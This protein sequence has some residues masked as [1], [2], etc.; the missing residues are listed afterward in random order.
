VKEKSKEVWGGDEQS[1]A[2]RTK[3][4]YRTFT[5]GI[6]M[7]Q[8]SQAN[9]KMWQAMSSKC[10]KAVLPKTLR[11]YECKCLGLLTNIVNNFK[12]K[13]LN[14]LTQMMSLLT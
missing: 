3:L 6:S 13:L 14:F 9:I 7:I 12:Y 5:S 1:Q 8:Y 2:N 11:P 4:L 10:Y